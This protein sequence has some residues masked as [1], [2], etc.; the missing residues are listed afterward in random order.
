MKGERRMSAR[1][2]SVLISVILIIAMLI[3]PFPTWL[4]S[5]LI[6]LNITLALLVI[7]VSMNMTEPLQFSV[8]P[9]LLLLLTL[10]R[11]GLNVSTTRA[12]LTHGDAGGVVETFGTFVVG[13]NIVVGLILFLI[14]IIIQFIVITKGSERVSEVAARFT[15]DAMP[16]KQMSIDADLNAGMI[17][18]QQARER[19]QKVSREA[20][21]YGAMDGASKF[22]KGDAI[23][24]IIIVFINLTAG[25]IIGMLQQGMGLADAAKHFS[26]LSVG[27]G[28]VS[29]VPALLISTATG[30]V[31][32]RAA[33]EG[34]L[35]QEITS[36]LLAYP[37]LLYVAGGTIF[38]LGLFTPINDTLTIPVAGMLVFGGYMFSKV[39][40]PDKLQLEQ[41]EESMQTDEMKS[42]ESVISLINVDP[43]EFEFGYGLIPL[44][45]TNQGGDLLDR[46]VMIRR[47]LAIELGLI[48][49]VVRIRDNIQLQ[50]NE[51]RLKIKGNEM[52]RG[53][54]LLDHYLAMSPGIEDD[55][56][57]GIDTIEPS[58]GLPAKWITEEMKE[59]AEIFGY[60]VVDPPSVVSTHV[61]EVIK[62]NAHELLGRQETKQLIDHVKESY[63]ILIEEVTPN[64]LSVGEVQKV[65]A[66]L[67][68]ENVSIRNLPV[69]FETLAD[70][71]KVTSD[72]D[73]LAEYVRQ[74]LARQITNQFVGQ[75]ETLKVATLSGK[76]EKSVA[77]AIQQTEHGN[78]LALDPS[79][80]QRILESIA[81]TIEQ[82]SMLEQTPIVLCSPAVRMYV[83]QLTE[84]Y[85]PKVPILSYNELEANVEVQSVGVVNV[86]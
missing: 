16:G 39:P 9:S 68:K 8:F 73:I 29:Q 75:G 31:V 15:L 33:S 13:G 52:A 32:T 30:I 14:L 47:Q 25:I 19:R 20:D 65:L 43:I 2:L 10:F 48:I 34:N 21:F 41:M 80:S 58:F 27:D 46:I 37:K 49:P 54:L 18:E 85:F 22:V 77:D 84:R 1:D 3:I 17:S 57:E 36:Q 71:G 24:S 35:G 64:P 79:I 59:R 44:A 51:Y 66:K 42:P 69:I 6:I 70:F 12:I 23:A 81:A 83:R 72:T 86:D 74:A 7:L 76:V 63:P 53:E 62:A 11:L 56:I 78:Y 28:I 67:L 45:D 50:P 26:L 55:S 61:T 60:T 4:L 38:L 5:I 40:E 82:F